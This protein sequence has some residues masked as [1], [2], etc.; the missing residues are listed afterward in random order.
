MADNSAVNTLPKTG[1]ATSGTDFKP[2][3]ET[4]DKGIFLPPEFIQFAK[5][6]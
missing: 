5:Q 1:D 3:W 2:D 4:I 6:P